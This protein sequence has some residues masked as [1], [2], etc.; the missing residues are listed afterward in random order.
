MNSLKV[1]GKKAY[2]VW[3]TAWFV[4]PFLTSYPFFRLLIAKPNRYRHA[5]NLNRMWAKFQLRMYLMPVK[6]K[7]LELLNPS[8]KY[9]FA[10]N[11]SSY[12]DIP[13]I[14]AAVP[15]FLNF[16]GKK[17][18]TKVPLWGKIYDTLYISVDRD[19]PISSAKAYIA[20]KKSLQEG[21]SVVIFP[22]GKI[23][24]ESGSKLL[25]FKDGPF[26]LAIEQ[27][28]PVVPITM[29]Y[30]HLF[31]PD[32]K[33]KLIIRYH[34]LEMIIHAPI[35]TTGLTLQDVETLKAQTFALIQ[36][37]LD[38]KNHEHEHRNPT[39]AGALSPAGI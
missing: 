37:T 9:I 11:H 23:S 28:I 16:V 38:Q 27:Q 13:M 12:I 39:A 32:V 8:Q 24:P 19:S 6:V 3:C 14:L 17:S 5:H 10:P 31:L 26:K 15:G 4:L 33:G 21:R 36:E 2:A 29:P 34:P 1:I 22:E 25:P 35:P 18:L 7:G 30:N 20:S